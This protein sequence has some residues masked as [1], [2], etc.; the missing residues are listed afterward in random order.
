M[1]QPSIDEYIIS[2]GRI[3]HERLYGR[4]RAGT[5]YVL[6]DLPPYTVG[7]VPGALRPVRSIQR[8]INEY[9]D[10]LGPREYKTPK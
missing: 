2:L 8:T 1:N 9:L 10:G 4:P 5:L 7:Y 6:S 3:R